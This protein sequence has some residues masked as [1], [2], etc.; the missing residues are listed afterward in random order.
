LPL[1][2][3]LP[4]APPVALPVETPLDVVCPPVPVVDPPVVVALLVPDDA[5]SDNESEHAAANETKTTIETR[6]ERMM[7]PGERQCAGYAARAV[8]CMAAAAQF[9]L[10]FVS[11]VRMAPKAFRVPDFDNGMGGARTPRAKR[12]VRRR[13]FH[14]NHKSP[15]NQEKKSENTANCTPIFSRPGHT[16]WWRHP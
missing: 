6:A 9:H 10:P 5:A 3:P 8:L 14:R 16:A 11:R 13:P 1:E 15:P 7:T 4:P 2:P 12:N